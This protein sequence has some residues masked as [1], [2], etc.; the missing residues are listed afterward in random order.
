MSAVSPSETGSD[1]I[2]DLADEQCM[3]IFWLYVEPAEPFLKRYHPS[4][5]DRPCVTR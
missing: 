4:C 5:W 2:N 3:E 1:W